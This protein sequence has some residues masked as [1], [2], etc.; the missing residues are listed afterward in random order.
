MNLFWRKAELTV[1][2]YP[3]QFGNCVF[4]DQQ[5]PFFVANFFN[6]LTR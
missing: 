3:N 6:R 5:S 1:G 4:G 2:E